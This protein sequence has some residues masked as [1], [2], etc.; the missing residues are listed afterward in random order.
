[1]SQYR[2]DTLEILQFK[3]CTKAID[4]YKQV[5]KAELFNTQAPK[6]PELEEGPVYL[7][8]ERLSWWQKTK[9]SFKEFLHIKEKK[10]DPATVQPSYFNALCGL[11][12]FS[13]TYASEALTSISE[14]FQPSYQKM[15]EGLTS[16]NNR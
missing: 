4:Y 8:Q 15:E 16:D 13:C 10:P 7:F 5:L 2:I 6:P 1:M 12:E 3:Y 14:S 11:R 9:R